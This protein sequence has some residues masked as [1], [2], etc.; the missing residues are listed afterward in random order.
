MIAVRAGCTCTVQHGGVHQKSCCEPASGCSQ[1]PGEFAS[2]ES[3]MEMSRDDQVMPGKKNGTGKDSG[4]GK[5]TIEKRSTNKELLLRL[6]PFSDVCFRLF[7]LL[8]EHTHNRGLDIIAHKV[9]TDKEGSSVFC[10]ILVPDTWRR[11][12]TCLV[13]VPRNIW[14]ARVRTLE[15][16]FGCKFRT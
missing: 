13:P 12:L 16:S 7:S 1:S 8:S 9:T 10:H 3:F 2:I 14:L 4:R 5:F 11:G 15:H 6:N